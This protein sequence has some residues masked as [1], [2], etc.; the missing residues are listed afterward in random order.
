MIKLKKNT[1]NLPL[2]LPILLLTFF[3]FLFLDKFPAGMD[4]DE[5]MYSLNGLAYLYSGKDLSGIPFPISTFRSLTEGM[6]AIV[7]SLLLGAFYTFS[8]VSQLSVRILYALL[9]L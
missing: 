6:A 9:S 7:P 4:H 3:R 1:A 2:L 5:I 8:D